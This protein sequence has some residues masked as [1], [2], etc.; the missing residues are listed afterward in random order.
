[1]HITEFKIEEQQFPMP[2]HLVTGLR[3]FFCSPI[4]RNNG[5]KQ[6]WQVDG[7]LGE[8]HMWLFDPRHIP[9]LWDGLS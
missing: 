7:I 3:C 5:K 6:Y 2:Q 8:S 1:M 9:W 4:A